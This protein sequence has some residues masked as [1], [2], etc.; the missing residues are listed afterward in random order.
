MKNIA[1]RRKVRIVI[2]LGQ[3]RN[4]KEF[5]CTLVQPDKLVF[6]ELENAREDLTVV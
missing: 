3:A 1:A 2:V 5:V 6:V 4:Q